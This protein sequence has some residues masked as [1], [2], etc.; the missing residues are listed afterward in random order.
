MSKYVQRPQKHKFTRLVCSNLTKNIF[1]IF[2]SLRKSNLCTKT[3]A[4]L[5][6]QVT[7]DLLGGLVDWLRSSLS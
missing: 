2:V 6:G 5:R 1:T 4:Q 7:L 3:V